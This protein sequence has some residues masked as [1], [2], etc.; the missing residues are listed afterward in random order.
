MLFVYLV[1]V[2]SVFVYSVVVCLSVREHVRLIERTHN[3]AFINTP[4][5]LNAIQ[6][7]WL[8]TPT[9][10]VRERITAHTLPNKWIQELGQN[11]KYGNKMRF[12]GGRGNE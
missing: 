6:A 2:Y 9:P 4:C 8:L 3:L 11:K 7:L 5:A 1:F 12:G 10:C